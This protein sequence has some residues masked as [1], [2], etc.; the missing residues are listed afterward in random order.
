MKFLIFDIWSFW[1]KNWKN[2][3]KLMIFPLN[4]ENKVLN[5]KLKNLTIGKRGLIEVKS[6]DS[7][8]STSRTSP[9]CTYLISAS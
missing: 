2:K 4:F 7:P 1:W 6:R 5:K 9:K 3:K 8:K